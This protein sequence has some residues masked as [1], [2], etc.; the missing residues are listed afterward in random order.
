MTNAPKTSIRQMRGQHAPQSVFCGSCRRNRS[1]QKTLLLP[2]LKHPRPVLQSE[3]EQISAED[4]GVMKSRKVRLALAAHPRTPRRIALRVIRELYTFELMQFALTPA[5]A[6]DLKRVADELLVGQA[7]VDHASAS[8]FHW[9][10]V[11]RRWS[12]RASAAR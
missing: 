4:A 3:I 11:L 5:A 1:T 9:P 8:E 7:R 12:P 2:E 6:A 10:G